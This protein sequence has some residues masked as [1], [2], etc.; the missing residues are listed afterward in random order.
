MWV[1]DVV[2]VTDFFIELQHPVLGGFLDLQ[3]EH[4]TVHQVKF[5]TFIP[6][7]LG[8]CLEE[9]GELTDGETHGNGTYEHTGS[10][11][12]KFH[13][14]GWNEFIGH[15]GQHTVVE[16]EIVYIQIST[17]LPDESVSVVYIFWGN[18]CLI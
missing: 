17:L 3:T 12:D 10:G 9:R 2:T 8:D 7:L 5:F 1:L 4:G 16:V 15:Q 6:F 14:I 13:L 11:R 18:P